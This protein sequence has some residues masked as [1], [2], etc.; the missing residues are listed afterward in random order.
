MDAGVERTGMYLQRLQNTR[1]NT[2][3]HM[4]VPIFKKR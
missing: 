1:L 3:T 4:I 2:P